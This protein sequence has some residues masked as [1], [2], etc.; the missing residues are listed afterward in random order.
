MGLVL[1]SAEGWYQ[2]LVFAYMFHVILLFIQV[3]FQELHLTLIQLRVTILDI[4]TGSTFKSR[5]HNIN[6]SLRKLSLWWLSL[7]WDS[8]L[9]KSS[10]NIFIYQSMQIMYFG[11]PKYHYMCNKRSCFIILTD[12]LLKWRTTTTRR[13]QFHVNEILLL[14]L[15]CEIVPSTAVASQ[16]L[17]IDP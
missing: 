11:R 14:F 4:C 15:L 17:F 6:S 1:L 12:Y 16:I 5:R 2:K 8:L 10:Q 13:M 3:I 7:K 9:L